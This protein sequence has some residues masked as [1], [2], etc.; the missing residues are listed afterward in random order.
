[1]VFEMSTLTSLANV[2]LCHRIDRRGTKSRF[3]SK[4]FW[5]WIRGL[6]ATT[7]TPHALVCVREVIEYKFHPN[8][9]LSQVVVPFREAS[10]LQ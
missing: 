2:I 7:C 8:L 6:L 1:M 9:T 4:S 3:R 10:V 5:Q